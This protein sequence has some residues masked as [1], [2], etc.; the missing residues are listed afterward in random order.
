MNRELDETPSSAAAGVRSVLLVQIGRLLEAMGGRSEYRTACEVPA[1]SD[2]TAEMAQ[3][4]REETS[5]LSM[6]DA[7]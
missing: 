2:A 4:N 3:S 1:T 6:K 5:P 7:P